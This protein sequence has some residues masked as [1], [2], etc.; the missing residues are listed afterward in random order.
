MI[1]TEILFLWRLIENGVQ[2]L[3]VYSH[4]QMILR[5]GAS[6]LSKVFLPVGKSRVQEQN[7]GANVPEEDFTDPR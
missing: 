5:S 4:F 1:I 3:F 6:I 7:A 2:K